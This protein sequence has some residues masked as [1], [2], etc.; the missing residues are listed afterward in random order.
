M[1]SAREHHLERSRLAGAGEDVV[2]VEELAE[3]EPVGDQPAG[4]EV[5]GR[6][7]VEQC[8]RRVRVDQARRDGDVSDPQVL[9]VERGRLAVHSDVGDPSARAHEPGAQLEGLG[10]P[11]RLDRVDGTAFVETR[12]S[13]R[14]TFGLPGDVNNKAGVGDLVAG[15]LE[16]SNVDVSEQMTRLI[17]AQRAYSMNGQ[18]LTATDEMMSRAIDMKR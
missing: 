8:G 11:D 3:R 4:V 6:H 14:V 5:T 2:R 12:N 13:G 15:A 17:V 10:E 1:R 9:E 16:Q 18:V 7:K